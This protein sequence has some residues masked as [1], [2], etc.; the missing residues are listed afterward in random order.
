MASGQTLRDD[1]DPGRHRGSLEHVFLYSVA[2][3]LAYSVVSTSLR[4]GWSEAWPPAAVMV[5][6]GAGLLAL[7]A[8]W[9]HG[10]RGER[11]S[12]ASG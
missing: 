11:N 8:K 12:R 4:E 7:R 5:A 2:G 6:V 9:R 1:D 3:G 10:T